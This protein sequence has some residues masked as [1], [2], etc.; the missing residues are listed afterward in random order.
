M[1]AASFRDVERLSAYLDGELSQAERARLESRLARDAG[2]SAA[3]DELRATRALLRRTPRRRAPRSFILTPKMA[4]LRPPLPR[5]VPVLRWA[6]AVATLLLFVTFAGNLLGPIALGAQAPAPQEMA[7]AYGGGVG[8]GPAETEAAAEA[9]D[10]GLIAEDTSTPA[11]NVLLAPAPAAEATLEA[12]PM[13]ETRTVELSTPTPEILTMEQP[14]PPSVPQA[15]PEEEVK[16]PFSLS[17][18]QIALLALAVILGGAAFLL[19]WQ[20][21]RAFAKKVK[22]NT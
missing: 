2:L 5:A 16:P 10:K 14:V 3:L 20:T 9:A 12:T 8:G 21:N 13:P 4:S 17:P 15:M 7:P 6:T 22:R 19:R 18:L 11:A 1:T